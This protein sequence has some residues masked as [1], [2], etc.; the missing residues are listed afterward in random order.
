M[1]NAFLRTQSLIGE[2][3]LEKLNS[4]KVAVFG[5]GGVG[6]YC[7]EALARSGVGEIDLID[8]DKIDITNLNRQIT[9][10]CQSIGVLKTA[11]AKQRILSINP[12]CKVEEYPIFF[13][14]ENADKID[15]KKYDYVIDAVDTVTAK[16]EIISRCKQYGVN[17]ISAMGAGNKL[18][19]TKFKAADIFETDVC[20]LCKVMRRELKKRNI[21]SLQVV[22]SDEKPVIKTDKTPASIAFVPSAMGLIIAGEVIKNL[23]K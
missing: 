4:S 11:A 16:L 21:E 18:D 9:A 1:D 8:G 2:S 3:A 6:G 13:L 22:Y 7:V 15:F 20:P 17:V 23:I 5:L 10:T 12:N 14:P 19:P